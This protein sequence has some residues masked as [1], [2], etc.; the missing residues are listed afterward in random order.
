[1]SILE[2]ILKD[3]KKEVIFFRKGGKSLTDE[4]APKRGGSYLFW[5]NNQN[6]GH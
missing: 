3:E 1:V 2:E 5:K 4:S 6:L